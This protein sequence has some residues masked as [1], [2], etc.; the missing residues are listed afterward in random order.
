MPGALGIEAILQAMQVYALQVN[1][2]KQFKSPRF[3]QVLNHKISWKY[4]GQITPENKKMSL[5][6]HIS[7]I[8]F[9][10][11]QVKIIGDAS[12]WKEDLRIYEVKDIAIC[13]L[14]S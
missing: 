10:T 1:L 5:E 6:I 13:L 3:G 8:E 12:L 9:E 7:A 14:E 2:G 4:R 11:D